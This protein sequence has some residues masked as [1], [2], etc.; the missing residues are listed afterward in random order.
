MTKTKTVNGARKV[1][2][3]AT[4]LS[5]EGYVLTGQAGPFV[6]RTPFGWI[7][8]ALSFVLF[9][10]GPIVVWNATKSRDRFVLTFY[11]PAPTA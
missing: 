1:S 3:V 7:L 11:R 2:R 5:G 9:P 8:V 4:Q 10:I 6:R